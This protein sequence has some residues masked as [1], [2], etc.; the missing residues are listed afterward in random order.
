MKKAIFHEIVS[1]IHKM[2]P[3]AH[4]MRNN[5]IVFSPICCTFVLQF[6]IYNSQKDV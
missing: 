1:G 2:Y 3:D 6:I 4:E 5:Y